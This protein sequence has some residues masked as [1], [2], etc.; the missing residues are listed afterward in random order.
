M[1]LVRDV[2]GRSARCSFS[3]VIPTVGSRPAPSR[4]PAGVSSSPT[5]R[6]TWR[7]GVAGSPRRGGAAA[8]RRR[9][10]RSGR[11]AS[12]WPRCAKRSRRRGSF[13]PTVWTG[14]RE[15][16]VAGAG[17]SVRARCREDSAAL[18]A[19]PRRAGL[20]SRPTGWPTGRTGSRRRSGPIRYDT[21]FFVAPAW[22]GQ[23]PEP[24]GLEMVAARWIRPEDALASHRD[25]RAGAAAA[26]AGHP[27]VALPSTATRKRCS[28]RRARTGGPARPAA[29]RPGRERRRADPASA[30]PRLVLRPGPRRRL[31]VES[32]P[33][34]SDDC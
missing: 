4:F 7:R 25:A 1:I 3:S 6:P 26:H 31:R 14:A 12:G 18:R 13:S 32:S 15:R 30:R 8:P 21:R 17:A 2:P 33:W 34:R 10:R 9:A 29:H 20:A 27:H 16:G 19:P 5:R 23:V 11:S 28:W 22:P 24:D